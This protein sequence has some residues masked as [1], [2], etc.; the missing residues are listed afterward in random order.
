M[1]RVYEVKKYFYKKNVF[2]EKKNIVKAVDNVSFNIDKGTTFGLVGESGSGKTTLAKLILGILIPDEGVIE[3]DGGKDIVFQD[4]FCSLNPRMTIE[5]IVKEPLVVRGKNGIFIKDEVKDV[6]TLVKLNY[7]Q[8][9]NKYP[10]QFSG[11][12]RQ[13]IA[14]ARALVH[15]P[16][17]IVLD[18]PVSS[19]DV[20]IQADILNLLKDLQERKGLTYLFISHDLRVIEF[21]SDVVGVMREGKLVEIGTKEE[22]YQN[23]KHQYTKHLLNATPTI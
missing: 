13:R 23:P 14:I 11:G 18:E 1:L 17:L 16:D 15:C 19:L 20:S 22:V 8:V 6:L 3:I 9:I 5:Q 21:M 10:H 7:K 4:P 12:E 2:G